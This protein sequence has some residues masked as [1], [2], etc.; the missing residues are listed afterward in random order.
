MLYRQL[1]YIAIET[2][3]YLEKIKVSSLICNN[4]HVRRFNFR[5]DFTF[6]TAVRGQEISIISVE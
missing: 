1:S 2:F 3:K 4:D 5:L 6:P